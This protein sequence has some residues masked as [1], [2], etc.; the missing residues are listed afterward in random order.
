MMSLQEELDKK[1]RQLRTAQSN[2]HPLLNRLHLQNTHPWIIAP[3]NLH[4]HFDGQS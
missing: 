1:M 2:Q 3:E 4:P